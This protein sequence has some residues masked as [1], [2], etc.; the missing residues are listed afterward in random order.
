M[1]PS[2]RKRQWKNWSLPSKLTA[3]GTLLAIIGVVLS[4]VLWALPPPT[5]ETQQ[6]I[7]DLP[8]VTALIQTAIRDANW[9]V[10]GRADRGDR[11]RYTGRTIDSPGGN[12]YHEVYLDTEGK[13]TALIWAKESELQIRRQ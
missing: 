6:D 7:P 11:Y 12:R 8:H 5:R 3:V 10:I 4:L 1:I 2:K 13:K 9:Q